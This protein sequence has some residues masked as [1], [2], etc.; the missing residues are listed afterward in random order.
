MLL[1]LSPSTDR[2]AA[3]SRGPTK[4][5]LVDGAVWTTAALTTRI[6]VGLEEGLASLKV[7]SLMN[8]LR[9]VFI[10]S[11]FEQEQVSAQL[12]NREAL[13]VASFYTVLAKGKFKDQNTFTR[14]AIAES[15]SDFIVS[16]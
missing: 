4:E 1:T 9:E 14:Q 16:A 11:P 2:Q 15:L 3:E 10:V 13:D 8:K 12:A 7:S 6:D 5:S